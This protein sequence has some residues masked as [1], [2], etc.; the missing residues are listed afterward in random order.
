MVVDGADY[1]EAVDDFVGDEI[2]VVAAD[3]A[4]VEVVVLAAAFYERSKRGGQ[5]FRF[6]L[7]DEVHHV[8]GDEGGKPA[9]V[10]TRGFQVSGVP[11]WGGG[12]YSD[13]AEARTSS[14]CAFWD[15]AASPAYKT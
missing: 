15:D 13:L 12:H 9:D 2:G 10:F 1:A 14:F 7:R 4:V 6:V 11:A 5:F 8:I 3:F